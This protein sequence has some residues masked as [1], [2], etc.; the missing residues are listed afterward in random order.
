M[1]VYM[2][3]LISVQRKEYLWCHLLLRPVHDSIH[4]CVLEEKHHI[5]AWSFIHICKIW[6]Y[7]VGFRKII[8]AAKLWG[9]K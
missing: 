3:Y 7:C 2:W 1:Y 8:F 9:V 5:E 4:A 6:H